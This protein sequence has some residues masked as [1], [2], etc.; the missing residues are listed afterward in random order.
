MVEVSDFT[1]IS[2]FLPGQTIPAGWTC[3]PKVGKTPLNA[4][5]LKVGNGLRVDEGRIRNA[6]AGGTPA[7]RAPP[8]RR[9]KISEGTSR[10]AAAQHL[11]DLAWLPPVRHRTDR[12][13][14]Q[15]LA[16]E[17]PPTGRP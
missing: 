12:E 1:H 6:E 10:P 15:P 7:A 8:A 3:R 11:R 14:A 17:G 16:V 5:V 9:G 2:I 4:S 13:Y